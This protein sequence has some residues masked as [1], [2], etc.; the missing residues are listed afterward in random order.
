MAKFGVREVLWLASR[1][2]LVLAGTIVEGTI[3]A[4]MY[5]RIWLDSQA[6]WSLP[7]KSVEAI[8]R[9]SAGGSLVGLVVHGLTEE[10]ATVF[11]ELCLPGDAIEVSETEGAV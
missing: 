7:I 6:F 1:R 11:S 10:D 2:E 3:S 5:A 8:D 4:G 9:V